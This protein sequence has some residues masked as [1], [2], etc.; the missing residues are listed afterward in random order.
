MDPL[1]KQGLP[2]RMER[3]LQP[4]TTSIPNPCPTT[5][6]HTTNWQAHHALTAMNSCL[7]HLTS[8]RQL[9]LQISSSFVHSRQKRTS[10]KPQPLLLRSGVGK[11]QVVYCSQQALGS[12]NQH[13]SLSVYA[14]TRKTSHALQ[15][16]T[17]TYPL[18]CLAPF[19]HLPLSKEPSTSLSTQMLPSLKRTTNTGTHS[20]QTRVRA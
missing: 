19:K 18:V 17:L 14:L 16:L 15:T 20:L 12:L 9:L 6:A 1:P 7:S 3:H 11:T 10:W 2:N 5:I 4:P 8:L 13:T